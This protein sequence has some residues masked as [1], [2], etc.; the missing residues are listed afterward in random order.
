MQVTQWRN[1]TKLTAMKKDHLNHLIFLWT[2]YENIMKNKSIVK[3]FLPFLAA[4]RAHYSLSDLVK[5]FYSHTY[6]RAYNHTETIV[7]NFIT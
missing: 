7:L 6:T 2:I 3:A 1:P 4:I 5:F